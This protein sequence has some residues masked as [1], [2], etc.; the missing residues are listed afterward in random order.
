MTFNF[1][2][3]K[4]VFLAKKDKS[5][6]QQIDEKIRILCEKINQR[7]DYFTTSS[8]SGRIVLLADE[9]KKL[10]GL[11]LYR[12]HNKINLKNFKKIL[13]DTTKIA[14]GT[15]LFK[16][17]PALLVVACKNKENQWKL[18]SE[19]RNNG[20][21]KSGILS[22]DKKNLIELFATEHISFP[23][24]KNKKILVDDNFLKILVKKA[25]ENLKKTWEKIKRLEELLEEL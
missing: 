23:I 13:Q 7:K 25:N 20:W 2:N 8:C 19:A 3:S 6:M 21:K 10:P 1:E 16:Q 15:I 14:Q 5:S 18:F 4:K 12:T 17:E 22:M 24:I 11:F 9:E